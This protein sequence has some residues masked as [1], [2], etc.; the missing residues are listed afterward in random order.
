MIEAFFVEI[1]GPWIR[2]FRER[3]RIRKGQVAE[4]HS[5]ASLVDRNSKLT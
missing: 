4:E 5:A 3:R 1:L 2:G